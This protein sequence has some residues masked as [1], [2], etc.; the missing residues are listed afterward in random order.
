M[1]TLAQALH[2]TSHAS[3]LPEVRTR[4]PICNMRGAF[5]TTFWHQLVHEEY[6]PFAATG[7]P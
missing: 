4:L 1:H 3:P 6:E 2:P 7:L 5:A